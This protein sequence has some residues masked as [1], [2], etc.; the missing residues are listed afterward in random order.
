M[1]PKTCI[2]VLF[3]FIF[4]TYLAIYVIVE[5]TKFDPYREGKGAGKCL[6]NSVCVHVCE[7]IFYFNFSEKV[8]K[9]AL[10]NES[11]PK[12]ENT[13]KEVSIVKRPLECLELTQRIIID[14]EN[15][16]D[17]KFD[18]VRIRNLISLKLIKFIFIK[19]WKNCDL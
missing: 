9:D 10:S 19:E 2:F 14:V 8:L 18:K 13:K 4:L 17:W 1:K 15:R 5:L 16:S 7:D 6:N 11:I 12:L 3:G